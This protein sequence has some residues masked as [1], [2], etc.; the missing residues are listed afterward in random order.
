MYLSILPVV[1]DPSD[2][3]AS[4][5]FVVLRVLVHVVL[6]PLPRSGPVQLRAVVMSC[7]GSIP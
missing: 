1:S 5:T 6:E 7:W 2:D 4:C 3:A